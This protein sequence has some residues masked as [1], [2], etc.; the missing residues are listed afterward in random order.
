MIREHGYRSY[1]EAAKRAEALLWED[2][3][4]RERLTTLEHTRKDRDTGKRLPFA[5]IEDSDTGA[6][7]FI[8]S[9]DPEGSSYS[10]TYLSGEEAKEENRTYPYRDTPKERIPFLMALRTPIFKPV[11]EISPEEALTPDG[12]R[13]IYSFFGEERSGF[14]TADEVEAE[15]YTSETAFEYWEGEDGAT[16]V[17]AL[18]CLPLPQD[19]QQLTGVKVKYEKVPEPGFV[20]RIPKN[21][22]NYPNVALTII[23]SGI[24]IVAC[25]LF[26]LS[27]IVGFTFIGAVVTCIGALLYRQSIR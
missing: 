2:R 24:V 5:Y 25:S 23:V 6:T 18:L 15:A 7:A 26:C 10:L 22:P 13:A 12:L 14:L 9:L 27:A 16:E 21:V 1:E 17:G 4:D 20:G 8:Y 3:Q 19:L 11:R